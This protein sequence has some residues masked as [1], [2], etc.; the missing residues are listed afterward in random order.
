MLTKRI[1][2]RLPTGSVTVGYDCFGNGAYRGFIWAA[3]G[4]PVSE[5]R[6]EAAHVVGALFLQDREA[7]LRS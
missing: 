7:V 2:D 6:W 3:L 4:P 5:R 1:G